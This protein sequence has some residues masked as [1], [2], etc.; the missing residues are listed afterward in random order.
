MPPLLALFLGCQTPPPP[1]AAPEAHSWKEEAELVVS[2]LEEVQGLWESG[3]RPAAKTLAE[4]VYTDRFEPRLE[5]ALREM[6]GQKETAKLEYAFG[7]LSIVLDGKD[8][9]KVE[10]R[11]DDLERQVRSVAEAAARAFPPPGEAAA[12][13]APP[14]EVRAIVPDVPPNW[15]MDGSSGHEAPEPGAAA[16]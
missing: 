2:G 8:R 14:K 5:P 3:Q 16:P 15:E 1:V 12:P 7:Q 4:R 9:T 11:I 10:A 13:P 6:Q